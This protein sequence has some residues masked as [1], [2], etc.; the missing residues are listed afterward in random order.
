MS[1]T[2]RQKATLCDKDWW[3]WSV[4]LEGTS[5]EL[6]AIESVIYR[7]H[8]TFP[9]P[10]QVIRDRST[11]FRLSS[12]GWGGFTIYIQLQ[13]ADGKSEK[14]SHEL[15][16]GEE[17]GADAAPKKPGVFLSFSVADTKLAEQLRKM[18]ESMD[19]QVTSAQDLPAGESL[20][21]ALKKAIGTC[22]ALIP[23]V[24]SATG[25][26][27]EAEV[28]YAAQAEVPILPVLVGKDARFA[29]TL[30]EAQVLRTVRINE[31][32]D[33]GKAA[34]RLSEAVRTAVSS[35]RSKAPAKA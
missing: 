32:E 22:D 28:A 31:E 20:E 3:D 25:S 1:V 17:E 23:I 19:L 29:K 30:P 24:S 6:D 35:H 8:P 9:D 12:S 14:L 26:W 34:K 15:V 5:Q 16:L 10:V 7:L 13:Y 21:S 27:V 33:L 18:L 2:T 4:W 11:N